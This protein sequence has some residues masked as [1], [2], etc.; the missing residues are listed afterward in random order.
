MSAERIEE[1]RMRLGALDVTVAEVHEYLAL[2]HQPLNGMVS[3][4][5]AEFFTERDLSTFLWLYGWWAPV[6]DKPQTLPTPSIIQWAWNVNHA[7]G[8]PPVT[9]DDAMQNF[10]KRALA[11]CE[12]ANLDPNNPGESP[13]DRKRRI[14]AERMR[15]TRAHKKIPDKKLKGDDTLLAQVRGLEA[16]VANL[17]AESKA[18]E[19]ELTAHVKGHQSKM[20]EFVEQRKLKDAE[21]RDRINSLLEQI[22]Q[23]TSSN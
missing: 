17:K 3:Q 8:A 13:E 16:E 14:N 21:Y 15:N 7:P 1:L 5:Y 19:E 11:Y 9:F 18:V 12:Q 10:Y 23:L 2:N 6:R 4:N 20:M 22:Q